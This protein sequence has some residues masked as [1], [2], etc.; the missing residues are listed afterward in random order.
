MTLNR[1]YLTFLL[2]LTAIAFNPPFFIEAFEMRLYDL[3]IRYTSP[4]KPDPRIVIVGIDQKSLDNYGRWP[5]PR[6]RLGALVTK[7]AGFGVKVTALD[8]TFSS[9]ADTDISEIMDTI[10]DSIEQEGVD[11]KSPVFYKKF[12]D[13]KK[14]LARDEKFA[15][16]I[17]EAGN[18]VTGFAF[19]GPDE[20]EYSA[21]VEKLKLPI[22]RPHRI[23]LVQRSADSRDAH[24]W[25]YV[26]GVEPNI[27]V[28]QDAGAA[29]GFLNSLPG[30]DGVIRS[31]PML[32]EFKNDIYPAMALSTAALY[33]DSLNDMRV[34]FD[35]GVLAGVGIGDDFLPLDAHGHILIRYLG[36]DSTFPYISAAD[37]LSKPLTDEN[38]KRKLSGKIVFVGSTTTQI[39]DLRVS[40]FGFTAGV[41]I[42]ANITSNVLSQTMI[43]KL[44]WQNIFDSA[45]TLIIGLI[46]LVILKRVNIF[47]GLLFTLVLFGASTAFIYWMFAYNTIWLNSVV[48]SLTIPICFVT[49]TVYQYIDEQKSKRFIKDAF[50]RYLSPKVINQLIDNP[51]LLKLGGEKR[52]MTAYFSDVAGFTS[53]SEKLS[54]TELV[55]LLNEYLSEMSNIIQE[56]EGTVDKYEGDAIIAFW[57]A[58]IKQARHAEL[59]VRVA[60]KMQ[61]KLVEMREKWRKEGKPELQV[62]MGIN[63]GEMVVG[64]M[65]SKHRM[66]YT[67]MG[68][69]VNLAARL[70]GVNKYYGTQTMISEFTYARV[71]DIFLCRELDI[72]RV[73][74]KKKAIHLFEVIDELDNAT[75]EQR[76]RVKHFEKAVEAF[77]SLDLNKAEELFKS[78]DALQNDGDNE[79]A[80]K[81][82]L[83]RIKELKENPPQADWD[84]VYNMAK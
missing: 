60:V 74:G 76:Q 18:V 28:I 40:P 6:D 27:K 34:V 61:K 17:K 67:I 44:G 24:I 84:V 8:M 32:I 25:F 13:M 73:E 29:T 79:K 72:V 78:Y 16:S 19:H 26:K 50:G 7:L 51:G 69:P 83:D 56:H 70:E 46:L 81:L 52:E 45:V 31:Q 9:Q 36:P 38:F 58:P 59:C 41:E 30:R 5:W 20:A 23:K 53:I 82:Y 54:P 64:N 47:T 43:T 68:D 11:K 4:N 37:V 42:Q 35:E 65:G 1:I 57:G 14:N 75:D 62:R 3:L 49:I 15:R 22:I 66:D 55:A 63:T 21:E 71:K 12:N 10:G 48:P 39:Y 2:I 33:K 77:R 80:V